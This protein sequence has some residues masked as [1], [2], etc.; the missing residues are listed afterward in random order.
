MRQDHVGTQRD[1]LFRE[2]RIL[3]RASGC[4]TVLD[5]D[6]AALRPSAL[7]ETD[8]KCREASFHLGV[9]L[10]VSNQHTNAWHPHGFLRT[11]RQRPRRCAAE[12]SDEFASFHSI[13]SSA[14]S[15]ND[16]GIVRPSTL[17]VVRLITRSN[18][19]A[20]STGISAGFAPRRILST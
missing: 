3:I 16:S 1:Q 12:Q 15:R 4:K 8:T 18:L 17:A 10:G 7:G 13:T 14:R 2:W 6:V 19:A 9:V 5:L 20:C 11:R